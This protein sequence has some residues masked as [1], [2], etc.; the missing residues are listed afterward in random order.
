MPRPI[1]ETQLRLTKPFIQFFSNLNVW[2]YKW[3]NGAL[4]DKFGGGDVCVVQMIGAKSGLPRELPLMYVPYKE[5]VILVASLAG[6][7]R[8]PTW[9]YNLVAHPEI[10]VNLRGKRKALVARRASS[11]EKAAV[12]PLCCRHYRNFDLYQRRTTRDI[13]VFICEPPAG[14]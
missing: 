12:W 9:Y 13:P 6:G 8:H 10:E 14:L 4:M 7:P 5:G 2:L 3:S 11:A 1:T